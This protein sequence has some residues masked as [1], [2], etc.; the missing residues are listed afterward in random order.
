[1]RKM[2][3][4]EKAF[5]V[6]DVLLMTVLII[7]TL[8]PVMYVLF[9]SFSEPMAYMKNTNSFLLG[10][11]GFS[12]KSYQ[13]VFKYGTIWTGYLNTIFIVV[14]GTAINM[15]LTIAAAYVLSRRQLGARKFLTIAIMFTR[16]FSGGMIPS[17]LIVRSL[18]FMNSL[19]A[20]ILP[21]AVNTFN[22]VIMRTAFDGVP[23]SMEESAKLD[24]ANQLTILVRIMVP[25]VVPTIAVLVLYYGVYH[26]NSWFNA[27]LYIHKR[28]KYPLQL[29]LRE[30]IIENSSANDVGLSGDDDAFLSETI[31]YSTIVI[32][33]VPILLLY[34]FLQKYFVKGV[35]V[36]AVKG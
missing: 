11:V 21:V 7:I 35:M 16:Y 20:L 32:S 13:F 8:Y 36:G 28:E 10:P 24:G 5:Q 2:T 4:G 30:L 29:I 26:W 3:K 14:I 15:V 9:V 6:F 22:L 17:F 33:T 12:L 1:M 27:L 18:G 31:K 19:W 23:E 34:P 25:L